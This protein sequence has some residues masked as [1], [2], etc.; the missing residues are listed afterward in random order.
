MF[1]GKFQGAQYYSYIQEIY[2]YVLYIYVNKF[3]KKILIFLKKKNWGAHYMQ[4]QKWSFKPS[5]EE[6]TTW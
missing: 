4:D 3:G 5:L 6:F 2:I 1:G